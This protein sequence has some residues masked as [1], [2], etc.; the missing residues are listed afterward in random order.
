MILSWEFTWS[1]GAFLWADYLVPLPCVLFSPS[2]VFSL[3]APAIKAAF[4]DP[5]PGYPLASSS[6][7]F[8]LWPASPLPG[9]SVQALGKLEGTSLCFQNGNARDDGDW[10]EEELRTCSRWSRKCTYALKRSGD[11]RELGWP[12]KIWVSFGNHF[13]AGW[14]LKWVTKNLK[15]MGCTEVSCSSGLRPATNRE[16]PFAN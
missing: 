1:S 14:L 6:A 4:L 7:A 16:A 2:A 10:Q 13:F 8:P 3:L 11:S 5:L 9:A 15:N 12:E